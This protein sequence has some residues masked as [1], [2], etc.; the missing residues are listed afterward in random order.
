MRTCKEPTGVD[1]FRLCLLILVGLITVATIMA[2]MMR[3]VLRIDRLFGASLQASWDDR[4]SS[5]VGHHHPD[6]SHDMRRHPYS[7]V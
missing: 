4:L 6:K 7:P 5:G 1:A 2:A 3:A